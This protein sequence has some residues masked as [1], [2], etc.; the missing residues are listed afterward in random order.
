MAWPS[1]ALT[2]ASFNMTMLGNLDLPN[3][4]TRFGS[5]YN[6]CWGFRHSNGTEIAIIGGIEDIF[7]VDVTVPADIDRMKAYTG[8]DAVM[9]GRGSIGNPCGVISRLMEITPMLPQM[10]AHPDS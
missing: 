5:Q 10:K 8:C 4:P 1:L 2:Q 3:L 9:I 6:D 7:F